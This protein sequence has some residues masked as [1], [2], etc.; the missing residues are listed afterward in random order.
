M[1]TIF[2]QTKFS[3]FPENLTKKFYINKKISSYK[4]I[5]NFAKYFVENKPKICT[6][7][8]KRPCHFFILQRS[9]QEFMKDL[10]RNSLRKAERIHCKSV[11]IHIKSRQGFHNN[12]VA[13]ATTLY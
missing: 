8:L 5:K 1:G 12:F 6:R 7:I 10:L 3:S 11:V 4:S 13:T 2:H 9:C